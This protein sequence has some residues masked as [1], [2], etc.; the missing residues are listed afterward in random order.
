[1]SNTQDNPASAVSSEVSFE[2]SLAQLEEIVTEL[3]AGTPGLKVS[4]EKFEQAMTLLR[5]CY[6]TLEQ[7]EQKI[8]QL[9]LIDEAGNVTTRPFDATATADRSEKQPPAGPPEKSHDPRSSPP[10]DEPNETRLF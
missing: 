2:E 3:E 6:Q 5:G 8:E 7:A 10:A 4:I 9:T 1:M